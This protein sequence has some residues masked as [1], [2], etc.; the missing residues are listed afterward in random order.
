[1][2]K[3]NAGQCVSN[4]TKVVVMKKY[5]QWAGIAFVVFYLLSQP[6][7]AARQVNRVL[8]ELSAAGGSL[9]TFVNGIG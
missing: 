5:L 6:Q 4:D 7:G 8:D 1:L 2:G 9:A 3:L